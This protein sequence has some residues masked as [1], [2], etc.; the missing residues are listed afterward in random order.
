MPKKLFEKGNPG[1]K[2]GTPN[3]ITKTVKDTVLEVFN[4]LQEDPETDLKA[5]ATK[6][7]R[8]FYILASKLIPT[9]VNANIAEKVIIVEIKE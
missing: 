3:K 9:E 1:R 6:N 2:K 5:F 8:D 7:P 4:K